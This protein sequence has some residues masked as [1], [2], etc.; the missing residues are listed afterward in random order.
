MAS[1]K[2]F[3]KAIHN[4]AEKLRQFGRS[5]LLNIPLTRLRNSIEVVNE[6]P[7]W[8]TNREDAI[9]ALA[10]SVQEAMDD[11]NWNRS[12]SDL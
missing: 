1:M 5:R 10:L 9:D 6:L 12:N 7:N 8:F 2:I 11:Y 3:E 4:E